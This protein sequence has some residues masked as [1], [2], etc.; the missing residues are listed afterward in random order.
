MSVESCDVGKRK[1]RCRSV[2]RLILKLEKL[3][4]KRK[5]GRRLTAMFPK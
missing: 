1:R 3:Q 2:Y 4:K 5:D